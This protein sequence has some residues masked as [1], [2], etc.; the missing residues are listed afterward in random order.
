MPSHQERVRRNYH[1]V[2]VQRG[3][4]L[5][6]QEIHVNIALTRHEIAS[7][8]SPRMAVQMIVKTITHKVE[9]LLT[10]GRAQ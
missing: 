8:V 3:E 2:M 5:A 1:T 9:A 10:R 4:D 7:W 6:A